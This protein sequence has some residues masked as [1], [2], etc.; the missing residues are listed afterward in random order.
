MKYKLAPII[1]CADCPNC[2]GLSVDAEC[3]I[4]KRRM[5]RQEYLNEGFPSDCPLE[6]EIQVA[7]SG[8]PLQERVI[9][10]LPKKGYKTTEGN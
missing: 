7:Q 6:D 9:K 1:R 5:S 2:I 3:Y 10:R 4:T 8:I